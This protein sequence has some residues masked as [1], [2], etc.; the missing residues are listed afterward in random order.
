MSD[1]DHCFGH[2]HECPFNGN[3]ELWPPNVPIDNL[4]VTFW[5]IETHSNIHF[6]CYFMRSIENIYILKSLEIIQRCV[7]IKNWK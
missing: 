7:H 1:V 3:F 6:D 5:E 2:R 4:L